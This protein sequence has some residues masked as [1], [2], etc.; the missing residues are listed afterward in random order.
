VTGEE[1][2][3][4][5]RKKGRG[6]ARATLLYQPAEVEDG[7]T[8]GA[9]RWQGV[10]VGLSGAPGRRCQLAAVGSGGW[11]LLARLTLNRG[12][13]GADWWAPLQ[14]RVARSNTV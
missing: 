2:K 10:G 12:E 5:E 14:S 6:G 13:A 9:M 1:Q 8:E 11:R 4:E 7:S 3:M